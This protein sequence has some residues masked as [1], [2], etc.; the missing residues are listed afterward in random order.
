MVYRIHRIRESARQQFRWALHVSG[1]TEVKPR[2]YQ[3]NGAV[4]AASPYAAWAVLKNSEAALRPG[5][6]LEAENGSLRIFKFVG[7][8]EARWIMPEISSALDGVPAAG[9]VPTPP[10]PAG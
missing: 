7:F 8:E 10:P 3:V 4:E 2:D 5:D 6:L 9:G 1:A